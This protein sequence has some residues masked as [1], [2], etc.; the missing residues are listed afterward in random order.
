[1]GLHRQGGA[2]MK[3]MAYCCFNRNCVNE[4]IFVH[5]LGSFPAGF[6]STALHLPPVTFHSNSG[7]GSQL[8]PKLKISVCSRNVSNWRTTLRMLNSYTHRWCQSVLHPWKCFR[9]ERICTRYRI[10]PNVRCNARIIHQ[11]HWNEAWPCNRTDATVFSTVHY[12]FEGYA[13]SAPQH[14]KKP[15]QQ[16]LQ[17]GMLVWTSAVFGQEVSGVP[18]LA[19]SWCLM[20]CKCFAPFPSKWLS[21]WQFLQLVEVCKQARETIDWTRSCTTKPCGM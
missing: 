4:A 7:Y 1:M 11:N 9:I 17:W 5:L 2:R 15:L 6:E 19:S 16:L 14:G 10:W 21:T 8:L 18:A 12:N 20:L 13:R 3:V